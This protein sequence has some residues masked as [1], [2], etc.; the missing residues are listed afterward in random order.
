MRFET[1]DE[2]FIYRVASPSPPAPLPLGEGGEGE[3]CAAPRT[4]V[5]AN[6]DIVCSFTVNS[7]LGINDFRTFIARSADGGRTWA[8]QGQLWP[9]LQATQSINVSLSRS[10][11]GD[12]FLFGMRFPIDTP[13]ETFWSDASQGLKQN[14]L[15]W[16]QSSDSGR[17]WSEP[18]V[19]PMQI[20]GSAEAPGAMCITRAGRMLAV[21]SPYNTFDPKLV[22][23]RNQVALLRSDDHGKTWQQS[24]MIRFPEEYATAAE[25]W[26]VELADGRLLGTC[27]KMNQ[28]DGSDFPNQYALSLDA[29]VT[30]QPTRS[31][32]I[33]GQSTALAPLPDGRALFI[34]NQRRH[35]EIG[36]WM[37]AVRPAL[38]D[39]GVE[40]D[41]IVWRAQVRS[42]K[43]DAADHAGWTDFAFGE[44][45]VVLHPDGDLLLALWCI[46]PDGAGIRFVRLRMTA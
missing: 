7:G 12:L 2:G 20:P 14:E 46:Q 31:T 16:A 33:M 3:A 4:A 8:L 28:K 43:G 40:V 27:W 44:P 45:A 37:A 22:V 5:A 1:V 38:F 18:A 29:G 25:A 30:W 34:Y 17:T 35:G 9:H 42:Q 13:G 23:D 19:I 26:V 36:V 41:Q 11:R 32:G 21:Y 24:S 15:I 10:P 39:F 6:G